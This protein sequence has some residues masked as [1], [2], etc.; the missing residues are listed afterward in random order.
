MNDYLS[1]SM[2]WSFVGLV[3]GFVLGKTELAIRTKL[4]YWRNDD[5]S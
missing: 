2:A 1:D 4:K 5:H 3:A